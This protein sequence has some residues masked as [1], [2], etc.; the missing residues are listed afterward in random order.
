MKEIKRNKLSAIKKPS[1]LTSASNERI[2][3]LARLD[4]AGGNNA[5]PSLGFCHRTSHAASSLGADSIA[6]EA[7]PQSRGEP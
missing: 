4:R 3:L 1:K 7:G 2:G 6:L 5:N